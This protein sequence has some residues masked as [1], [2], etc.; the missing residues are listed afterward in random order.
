MAAEVISGAIT[1][2]VTSAESAYGFPAAK[3]IK[4]IL[5]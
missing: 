5:E 4:E 1:R 3:D 2:A